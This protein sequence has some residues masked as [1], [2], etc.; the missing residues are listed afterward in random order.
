MMNPSPDPVPGPAAPRSRSLGHRLRRA[1][2]LTAGVSAALALLPAASGIAVSPATPYTQTNLVSDIPGVARITDPNLVNPWG[3]AEFPGGPLWVAD[4]NANVATLYA[5]D[6][7]GSALTPVSL[8]VKVPGGAPTGQVFNGT[9]GFVVHD[10]KQAGPAKFIF[11]SENGGISGWNPAVGEGAAPSTEAQLAVSVRHAVY[12][13]L[14]IVGRHLYATNFHSGHVEVFNARFHRVRV[15]GA[16]ADPRIPRGYAPF[17]IAPIGG[18][19]YVTYAK[20][21]AQRHDDVAG[22]GH[23]FVDVY[24]PHGVLLRRLVRHGVLNSP[25]G[26]VIAPSMFGTFSNDLLVA[27]FGDGAINAFDPASGAF[28]GA[29]KNADGNPIAIDDLWGLIVGDGVAGTPQTVFFTAG[30]ADEGH[31]LLGAIT[32]ASY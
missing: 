3:V 16:F 27:N 11:S 5:G 9:S 15:P 23:G 30:I 22:P 31:G 2:L 14:A 32:V 29:L 4:N 18:K 19:L 13:G 7:G 24:S 26:M 28:R 25:W 21:N 10:G 8:V 6:L 20:Q 17:G 12:K 1:G